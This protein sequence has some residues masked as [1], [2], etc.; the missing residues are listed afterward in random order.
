MVGLDE[1]VRC[2]LREHER[3]GSDAREATLVQREHLRSRPAERRV[4]VRRRGEVYFPVE[5]AFKFAGKPVERQTW[6]G[7][8]PTRTFRFQRSEKL[9]WVDVDPDRKIALDANWSNNGRRMTP[10]ARVSTAWTARWLFMVQD[11]IVWLGR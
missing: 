10:D 5:V 4:L 11:I 2:V 6:D 8:A 7:K 3:V 9:E 1:L